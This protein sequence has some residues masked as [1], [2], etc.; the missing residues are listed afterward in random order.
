MGLSST[1]I[2]ITVKIR[3][4][5]M[6]EDVIS[7]LISG[8]IVAAIVVTVIVWL[9]KPSDL[10]KAPQDP[11]ALVTI[12]EADGSMAGEMLKMRLN[13]FGI[14]CVLNG[15]ITARTHQHHLLGGTFRPR[16]QIMVRA[17]DVERA[18]EVLRQS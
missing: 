16:V 5:S 9:R 2:T 7:Y 8:I 12:F 18:L 11:D 15:E 13:S 4:L 10:S 17:A 14:D 6:S 3:N 1:E